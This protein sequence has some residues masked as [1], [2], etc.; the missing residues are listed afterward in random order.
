VWNDAA[1]VRA[2]RRGDRAAF[3]RLVERHSPAVTMRAFACTRSRAAAEDLA[4][5]T[6]LRAMRGLPGLRDDGAFGGWLLT[7]ADN[8]CRNWADRRAT[9]DAH[10]E[11]VARAAAERAPEDEEHAPVAE[12]IASLAPEMQELLAMR[13]ERGMS[14]EEIAG[15]TGRPLGT[16]TKML[17]RAYEELRKRLPHE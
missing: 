6:I 2:A 9:E 1:D 3:H 17:S 11:S 10:R 16:V 12:A 7:I 13:F 8:L 5:E 14:C 15:E 4:Q